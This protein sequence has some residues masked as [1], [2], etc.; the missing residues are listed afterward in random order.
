MGVDAQLYAAASRDQS[1]S[2]RQPSDNVMTIDKHS[3]TAASETLPQNG[4]KS[5]THQQGIYIIC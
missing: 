2:A 5:T 1:P 4:M 3:T